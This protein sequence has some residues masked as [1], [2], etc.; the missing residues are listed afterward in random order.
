MQA[1]RWN[2]I[3]GVLLAAG[4]ALA[5]AGCG[6][7][8][9]RDD[10]VATLAP[11]ITL[12]CVRIA[13]LDGLYVGKYEVN[14]Q[15]FRA[16][17]PAHRSGEH[18]GLSLD[19][20]AQPAVQV[21]WEDARQ[22]C[23]WLTRT[24]GGGRWRFRLPTAA[25]WEAFAACGATAEYPWGPGGLPPKSWNYFGLENPGVAQKLDRSDGFR[26]S[27]P[28]RKSGVNAWGL[29][30]VGGNVWEWCEDAEDEGRTRVLKGASWADSA[31]LFLKT[32][33]RSSYTPD[34]RSSGLGFRVVAVPAGGAAPAPDAAPA[35]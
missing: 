2:G 4:A 29:Y 13:P 1:A 33:R 14:N 3:V 24:A 28:V 10:L 19:G 32:A 9:N 16:F 31:E 25:E 12:R 11:K 35:E 8:T 18:Q 7:R 15:Q 21:S 22:F 27:A 5:L 34:Y 30:G 17:R 20:D 6:E 26:V 23:D